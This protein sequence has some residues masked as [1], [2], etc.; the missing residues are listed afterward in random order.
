MIVRG[1]G[2]IRQVLGPVVD[3]QFADGELPKINDV[4]FVEG[5]IEQ[6]EV[7]KQSEQIILEV[8]QHIDKNV[9]RCLSLHSTVGLRRN[10]NTFTDYSPL[11]VP[12][13]EG[14]L[15]RMINVSGQP[16][17][18]LG[19]IEA[20]EK[21]PIHRDPPLFPDHD[22]TVEMLETGIKVID[23]LAPFPKGG[24]IGVFGGAGV[25]KTVLLGEL[26][27]RAVDRHVGVVVFAGV[28]ER[29]R[30]A[31]EL[32]QFIN[33]HSNTLKPRIVMVLGQMNESAG[34]RLR[35][36]LTAVTIA[37][38]FRDVLNLDVLFILDNLFRYIQAGAEV[39]GL[40]G[41]VP[42]HMGYQATLSTEMGMLQERL[43]STQ[44]ASM[45]SIQA[46]YVPSD[47]FAD[48]AV[49]VAYGHFDAFVALDRRIAERGI[50]P[51]IDPLT[52]R[53]RLLNSSEEQGV[54]F[55]HYGVALQVQ[56]HLER[57]KQ[58]KDIV[59]I[60]GSAELPEGDKA[61]VDRAQRMEL[62]L[63]Q[64]LY[65]IQDIGGRAGE[66]VPHQATVA[67]FREL[68]EGKWDSENLYEFYN[69]GDILSK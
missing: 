7:T 21:K 31:N 63:S 12:V 8:Q 55:T 16:V 36:A 42:S 40:L 50:H 15:G 41:R 29:S 67:R 51:A 9:A 49:A 17:D 27:R 28:G 10:S 54:G 39:S 3:V 64:P 48:P 56:R 14:L 47:D 57:Y 53:S 38:Y 61:I 2:R 33:R 18:G 19:P 60:L 1:K 24:K 52:C 13:G 37:E 22:T 5:G 25:G 4:V 69:R 44:A 32:W 65:M 66:Y 59:T 46:I 23:L 26:F 45:T 11:R 43:V 62:F 58:V 30:E 35:T 20:I 68:A 6:G 34:A